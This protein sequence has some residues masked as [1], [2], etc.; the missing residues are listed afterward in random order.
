MAFYAS[1][2]ECFCFGNI[3]G[4]DFICLHLKRF[5]KRD[6]LLKRLQGLVNQAIIAQGDVK[7][8]LLF[9]VTFLLLQGAASSLLG[10]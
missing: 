1:F 6:A 5:Q 2:L 9:I 3:G 8:Y 7:G 10:G 4:A